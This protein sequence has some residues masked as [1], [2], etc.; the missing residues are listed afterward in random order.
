MK[1]WTTTLLSAIALA[2]SPVNLPPACAW[3]NGELALEQFADRIVTDDNEL[4]KKIQDAMRSPAGQTVLRERAS[5]METAAREEARQNALPGYLDE[6]FEEAAGQLVLKSG[7]EEFRADVIRQTAEYQ[8]DVD[9]IQ[10]AIDAIAGQLTGDH[11]ADKLL[12]RVLSHPLTAWVLYATEV[13]QRIRPDERSIL[14]LYQSVFVSGPSGELVIRPGVRARIEEQLS[15]GNARRRA[16]GR[17]EDELKII[18]GEIAPVDDVHQQLK[19]LFQDEYFAAFCCYDAIGEGSDLEERLRN[20]FNSIDNFF[21]D[22]SD[23]RRLT[24]DARNEIGDLIS[25]VNGR[26]EAAMRLREPVNRFA[27]RIDAGRD[28]L[29]Q[30]VQHAFDSTLVLAMLTE[31]G[32]MR[33]TSGSQFVRERFEDRLQESS[34][35]LTVKEEQRDEVV[36][37]ARELL[38]YQRQLRRRLAGIDERVGKIAE[39]ELRDTFLSDAGKYLMIRAI[40]QQIA[41]RGYDGLA[42]WINEH[43]TE[44]ADGYVAHDDSSAELEAILEQV[45]EI[46]AQLEKD[47][48]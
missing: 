4:A 30:R 21:E 34:G 35:G 25:R 47:D 6:H 31:R 5:V 15:R 45:R 12:K 37:Y 38:Q 27:R 46:Q 11:E 36:E 44:T 23:G 18:S 7:Q 2:V 19:E 1:P 26:R 33:T 24:D 41:N 22:H 13:R 29:H 42:M 39:S 43:F 14:E 40:N 28:D 10:S 17:I 48:F 8:A 3:Q 9:E 20:L 16:L 32:D